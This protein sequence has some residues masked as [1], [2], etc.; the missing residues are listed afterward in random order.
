MCNDELCVEYTETKD[1]CN[2]DCILNL[3]QWSFPI[4]DDLL[5]FFTSEAMDLHYL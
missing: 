2:D 5:A 1:M 4:C 3:K